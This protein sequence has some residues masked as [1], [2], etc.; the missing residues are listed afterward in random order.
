MSSLAVLLF[1]IAL[2]TTAQ[3]ILK[4]GMTGS[5]SRAKQHGTL[6]IQSV[7]GNGWVWLGLGLF[8]VSALAW[9][10][11]LSR[12]PLNMAYPFNALGYLAIV[13]ASVWVSTKKPTSGPCSVQS[14]C[15]AGSSSWSP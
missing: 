14:W 12:V 7:V 8:G 15:A 11:T 6:L 2:S 5:A 4:Y 13:A 10:L 1:A 9:M 3:V